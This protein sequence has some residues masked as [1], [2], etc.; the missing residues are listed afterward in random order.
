[1]KA[2]VKVAEVYSN[3]LEESKLE[4]VVI[5]GTET[6]VGGL[7]FKQDEDD[8]IREVVDEVDVDGTVEEI[9]DMCFYLRWRNDILHNRDG[10]CMSSM[11]HWQFMNGFSDEILD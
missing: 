6:F 1:M 11:R 4:L 9:I 8:E 3:I 10:K 5:R 2:N 7:F